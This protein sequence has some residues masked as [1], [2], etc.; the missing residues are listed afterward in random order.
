MKETPLDNLAERNR[1]VTNA[2]AVYSEILPNARILDVGAGLSPY[3]EIAEGHALKYFSHDFFRYDPGAEHEPGLQNDSWQY[4][5]HDFACDILE[6]PENDSFDIILCT[7]VFE[8]I[9]DPVKAFS[10]LVNLTSPGGF[11]I[12]SVPFLSLMHQAPYYFSSGLSPFWFKHHAEKLDIKLEQLDVYGDY[13]DV[14]IQEFKRTAQQL[15]KF[16]GSGRLITFLAMKIQS[17]RPRLS[18]DLLGSAGY[19]TFFIGQKRS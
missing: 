6:I 1:L 10:K 13:L 18:T 7:E 2:L 9:P 17:C 8:H 4:P 3:R 16:R 15:L 12:I 11:I 14:V 5:E 19:G